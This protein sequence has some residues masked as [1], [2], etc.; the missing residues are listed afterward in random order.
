LDEFIDVELVLRTIHVSIA[1]SKE[2]LAKY[3]SI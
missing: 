1:E 3:G 2:M